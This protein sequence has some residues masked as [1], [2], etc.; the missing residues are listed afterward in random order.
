MYSRFG[1]ARWD[2]EASAISKEQEHDAGRGFLNL[3]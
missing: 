3:T 1:V 2:P